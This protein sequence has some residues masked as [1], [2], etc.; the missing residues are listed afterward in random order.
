MMAITYWCDY[1]IVF[2]V[3]C[4]IIKSKKMTKIV[5]FEERNFKFYENGK[6]KMVKWEG[7]GQFDQ[8]PVPKLF[9]V[10]PCVKTVEQIIQ[11]IK[12]LISAYHLI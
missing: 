11:K 8:S 3:K 2:L 12:S 5:K 10:I 1:F 7:V 6:G 9:G 4:N